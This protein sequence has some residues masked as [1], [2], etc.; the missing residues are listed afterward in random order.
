MLDIV[1][2]I[3]I[4]FH[5]FQYV[6]ERGG[7]K[8]YFLKYLSRLKISGNKVVGCCLKIG[9]NFRET[10][11]LDIVWRCRICILHFQCVPERG[12]AKIY[13]LKYLS[14]Q[15]LSENKVFGYCLEMSNQYSP[16]QYVPERCGAKILFRKYWS[17]S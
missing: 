14:R 12:G 5:C 9:E 3:Q 7:A 11:L 17:K 4:S 1:W 16:F 10:K 13:F 6:P 15:K 8:I 2:R